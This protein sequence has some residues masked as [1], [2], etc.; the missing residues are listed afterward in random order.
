MKKQKSAQES[1]WPPVQATLL[2]PRFFCPY[3]QRGRRLSIL[4]ADL[5]FPTGFRRIGKLGDQRHRGGRFVIR[6][7]C[8][9]HS[10]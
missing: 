6:F 8:M 9:S 3:T 5:V 2:A 7:L 10:L 1:P 4:S